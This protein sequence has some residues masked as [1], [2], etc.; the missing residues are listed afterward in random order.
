MKVEPK[1]SSEHTPAVEVDSCK[2]VEA[3]PQTTERDNSFSRHPCESAVDTRL[4]WNGDV[5]R[6]CPISGLGD[7]TG[8]TSWRRYRMG[9]DTNT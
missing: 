2:G 3:E 5:T 4:M 6:E 1:G 9:T 8:H 7:K